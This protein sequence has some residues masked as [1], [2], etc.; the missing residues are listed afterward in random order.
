MKASMY[1]NYPSRSLFRGGQRTLLA[2]FCVAVGVMAIVALQ[3]VGFM[4]QN[5]LTANT[6][7][8][9]NGDIAVTT[10]TPFSASDL[11]FFTQQ[12]SDG[13]IA[14]Y[15]AVTSING[16]LKAASG[17]VRSIGPRGFGGGAS[18]SSQPFNVNAV[19]PN[20]YH[21][22]APPTFVTP[23]NGMLSSLLSRNRVVVTQN[24]LD[25][26]HHKV[27]DT[28]SV[29]TTS[30][31]GSGQ[32]LHVTIAGVIA[33]TG[34][35]AQSR[36]L[37]LISAHDYQAMTPN[38]SVTYSKIFITTANQAHTDSEV[39]AINQHFPLA[40]TQTV[41][42]ALQ[43]QQASLDNINKFLEIAGLLAL[44]IGGIG[45]V[46]TMQVLLSRRKT[47]IAMLKTTG[48]RRMDLYALFGLEAGLLGLIGGVIGAGASIGVSALV[49]ILMLNLG[50]T[51]PFVINPGIVASGV[52]IGV[53]TALIFGLLPIVQAANIR[54]LNVIRDL[55]ENQGVSS[56]ALTIALLVLLT[57]LFCLLAIVILNNDVRL[58][59]EVVYGTFAFLLILSVFFSL[60]VLLVSKLAV[61]ERLDFRQ[62]ALI[63][64]GVAV[65][66]LLY[67]VLP[68]FGLLLFGI[69]LLGIVVVL[70]PR[71]WKVSIK[72]ALRNI[73]RQ[74]TRTTTTLLALFI[75]VFTIGV[76]LVLGQNL[77]SQISNT[78][79]QNLSYNV[80]VLTTGQDTTTLNAKL[81]TIPGRT[82][83][84]IDTFAQIKPVSING[85]PLQNF[86]STGSLRQ[87][88]ITTLSS[89]EGYNL[90]QTSPSLTITHGRN[91]TA[92]DANTGNVVI[93]DALASS[94]NLQMHLKV[95][96][97]ITFASADGYTLTKGTVV[98][99]YAN[100]SSIGSHLGTV[101][102][103][104]KTVKTL[105]TVTTV[106][107]V[108]TVTYPKT[109]KTPNP[110]TTGTLPKYP[111]TAGT[112]P[113]NPV[114]A[115][116]LPKTVKTTKTTTNVTT[117]V[118]Y[119]KIDSAQLNNALNKLGQIVPD[120]MVQNLASIGDYVGQLLN[121][122]I[123][124]LVAIA[125]LSLIAG[126]II[127]ANSV[128]L[129]M[130]ER[131]RELGIMKSV[132]YT[133]GIVLSEV[134]IENGIIGGVGALMAMLL[135][136]GA[137]TLLGKLFFSLTFSSPPLVVVGLIGGSVVLAMLTAILVAWHAVRVRPLEVLRYE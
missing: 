78:L 62:L 69:A 91:L 7:D 137:V 111:I 129:A 128:A 125:S 28:F 29:Y 24:F 95:G 51:I 49:R 90:A 100:R 46:N 61:P 97:T 93:S 120:A 53:A 83:T 116:T 63:L 86:L 74:R 87:E 136:T 11:S 112:L 82:K 101:L 16:S 70:V 130:L 18:A 37:M 23:S 133:S 92:S 9:N 98:G 36:S 113:K 21:I 39:K 8:T 41:A 114:T 19:D 4:L 38:T 50:F 58:G 109:G 27:G 15:T 68:V 73:G 56:I 22:V 14:N 2:I 106:T 127:I 55:N 132:G 33:N 115:G 17:S 35:F 34:T 76:V 99:T 43:S 31:A 12:K 32:T 108:P 13:K 65:S 3:L 121:S 54:P 30:Q 67:W 60:V 110:V 5:S 75:G 66:A 134:A 48:Y 44:L 57:V 64:V 105:S 126:V 102:A 6:R 72:L 79:S 10:Q 52:V 1:I 81:G 119:M 107:T 96:D 89:M 25:V 47:E 117:T 84:Q 77:Q 85:Q 124:M 20:N 94:G 45:I 59:I 42:D 88:E 135:A 40:S 104:T 118:T 131:R 71:T 123:E 80:I 26:Y 103:S 122:M